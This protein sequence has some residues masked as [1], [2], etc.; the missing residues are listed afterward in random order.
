M[1]NTQILTFSVI[2]CALWVHDQHIISKF[3]IPDKKLND[4]DFQKYHII[5][6]MHVPYVCINQLFFSYFFKIWRPKK[7]DFWKILQNY[8]HVKY[9]IMSFDI[10]HFGKNRPIFPIC[11]SP[12]EKILWSDFWIRFDDPCLSPESIASFYVELSSFFLIPRYAHVTFIHDLLNFRQWKVK[13]FYSENPAFHIKHTRLRTL[14]S[15]GLLV[16]L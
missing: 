7:N 12:G 16:G 8:I 10:T 5:C 13:P 2:Y 4:L 3:W 14:A 6:D 9:S 15:S 1:S 11:G